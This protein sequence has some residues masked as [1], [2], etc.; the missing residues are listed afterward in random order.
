MLWAS[1]AAWSRSWGRSG[2]QGTCGCSVSGQGVTETQVAQGR[3]RLVPG[4][5]GQPWAGSAVLLG[6]TR[7]GT[8]PALPEEPPCALPPSPLSQ[9]QTETPGV[10]SRS[11]SCGP[12][13]T[14]HGSGL[15]PGHFQWREGPGGCWPADQPVCVQI[16]KEL[17]AHGA[18]PNLPLTKG[19]GSALCVA[20]D[21]ITYEH[22]R[23]TDSK[24]A[25][26]SGWAHRRGGARV[27]GP[28]GHGT[29]SG[30]SSPQTSAM[31]SRPVFSRCRCSEFLK[32]RKIL[33]FEM[34][35]SKVCHKTWTLSRP[36]VPWVV[37]GKT[38]AMV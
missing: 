21:I 37:S 24:L 10:A 28:R 29:L 38:Q 7:Q 31:W 11:P 3:D 22:Q 14:W 2:G 6:Q 5:R 18:D 8:G 19:L 12:H 30:A 9:Q 26:V 32:Q 25:L 33:P 35:G 36:E 34:Y 17:L 16:V 27:V 15:A 4:V 13:G 20:C 1:W 23:G